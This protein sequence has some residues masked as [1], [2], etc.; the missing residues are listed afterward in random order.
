MKAKPVYAMT[1]RELL[2]LLSY[3]ALLGHR[4]N[5]E[6][7]HLAPAKGK[8]GLK[9]AAR[10]RRRRER[11]RTLARNTWRSYYEREKRRAEVQS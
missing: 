2:E 3:M 8:R 9:R 7:G 5:T 10:K 4:A 11:Q 6:A 1:A